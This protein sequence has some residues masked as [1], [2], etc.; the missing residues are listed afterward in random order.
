V[1]IARVQSFAFAGIDAQPVEVQ[2]Q[3]SGGL[4]NFLMVGL[5][6]KAVGEARE[7]VR[8]ALTSMGLAMPPKRVLVNL[9]PADMLKEG[10]H[11]DLPVAIAVLSAMEVLPREDISQY[12]A[13]GELSLDGRINAV[14]GV[15]PA[16]IAAFSRGLGL[17]CPEAQGSEAGWAGDMVVLGAADLLSLINHFRGSQVI[18]PPKL[19]QL[20][21]GYKTLDLADVR[22]METARRAL[23]IAA[24]GGHN[25]LMIG[26]PGGGKSM[27][28]ARLP[29]LLPDLSPRAALEVSMVHSVAGLLDDGR[30]VTR[31]PF[32]EPHHSA[33]QAAMS[34]GGNRA[35]PGEVSLAHRGVLFMDELPE[36]P[37]ATLEALRQ[38]LEA[39][40]TTVAR[41]AAHITY[42]ARFQLLAAMNPCRCGYLGDATRECGR[43]PRCGEDYQMKISGPL[44][45]R[46]DLVLEI[47]PVAPAELSRAPP[48]ESSAVVAARV[49]AAR[50]AQRERFGEEGAATNAEALADHIELHPA[51]RQFA[52]MAATRLRLS[53]RG[54]T[55]TLRVAR[56][57]ADLAGMQVVQRSHVAEALAYRHRLPGRAPP[58]G[59]G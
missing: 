17:I 56:T 6:D 55:R 49:A 23:E 37:R 2:V 57:I 46:I 13:L 47:S 45:D 1:S 43:A 27:L 4:P 51:A 54:F 42:P 58:P 16:A 38:P 11:F 12:A 8:A 39:G 35:K 48:G 14:A 44:L 28:A 20:G 59:S 30:L 33:S 41:A 32:R 25:M 36:F 9:A 50:A 34:G 22:G 19:G 26:P 31:P 5:P 10:S 52:E 3:I 29:G 40:H 53:A 7:R 15:L 24:A 18:S 21:A